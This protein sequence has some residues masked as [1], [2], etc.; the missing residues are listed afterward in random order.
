MQ[1][2]HSGARP[3]KGVNQ[4][5]KV[6]KQ[7]YTAQAKSIEMMEFCYYRVTINCRQIPTRPV[8]TEFLAAKVL[9]LV[10]MT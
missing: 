9:E 6:S 7:L 8:F 10:A 4:T 5:P 2:K 3:N 1:Q